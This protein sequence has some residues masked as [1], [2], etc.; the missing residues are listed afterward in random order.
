MF[1]TNLPSPSPTADLSRLMS[2]AVINKR[3]CNLLLTNPEKA[4]MDGFMGEKFSLSK[5]EVELVCSIQATNL[6]DFATQLVDG[7]I[8][9]GA[10]LNSHVKQESLVVLNWW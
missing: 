9:L 1:M 3:F 8:C 2:A 4:L 10:E 6:K 5:D 7:K